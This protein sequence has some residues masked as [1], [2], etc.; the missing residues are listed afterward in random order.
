MS[1]CRIAGIIAEYNPLHRGHAYH[2]E[3]TRNRTGAEA[4]VVAL[5]SD[6]LQRGE[7]ACVSKWTRTSMALA[8]GA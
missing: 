1:I 8:S 3:E 4:L 5:S 7:P 2:L 6:F